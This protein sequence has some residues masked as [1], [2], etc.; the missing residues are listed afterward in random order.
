MAQ[1]IANWP[2]EVYSKKL[3]AKFYNQTVFGAIANTD[4]EGEIKDSGSKV[5]IK[6]KPDVTVNDYAGTISYQDVTTD[7]ID[8]LID[9]QKY[10][11][12][13]VGDVT[14][15]QSDVGVIDEATQDA[16]SNMKI[17]VDSDIL[18]AIYADVALANQMT[19]TQITSANILDMIVD[20]GTVLDE[21]NTPEDGR[22]LVLPPWAC[23]MIKKSDLKDAS[24]SGDGTSILRPRTTPLERGLRHSTQMRWCRESP[25]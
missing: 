3:Q 17:A 9:K 5:R 6:M 8:L 10:Y 19:E 12:F 11:A 22:W 7:Y 23:G 21:S 16:A 20:A 1:S 18:A 25:S 14:K 13:K 2:N 24:V 15:A 4:W